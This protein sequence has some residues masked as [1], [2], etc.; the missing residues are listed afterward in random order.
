M[1]RGYREGL[2]YGPEDFERRDRGYDAWNMARIHGCFKAPRL[3]L[4]LE[5][6]L[7]RWAADEHQI[8]ASGIQGGKGV[9]M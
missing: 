1:G 7:P 6:F 3:Y 2:R 5:S 8:R 4:V 9:G